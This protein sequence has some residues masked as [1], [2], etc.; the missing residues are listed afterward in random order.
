MGTNDVYNHAKK[1]AI[2][3][4]NTRM[5]IFKVQMHKKVFV[6]KTF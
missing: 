5:A 3:I 4:K 6:M 1:R 2:D